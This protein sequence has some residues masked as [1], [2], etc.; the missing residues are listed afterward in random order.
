MIRYHFGHPRA[1]AL[2]DGDV[3][4]AWYQGTDDVKDVAWARIRV[5]A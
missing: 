1:A 2:P 3:I 4:A 5:G